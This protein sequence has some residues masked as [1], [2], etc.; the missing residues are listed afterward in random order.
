MSSHKSR[1]AAEHTA[2]A[3][4]MLKSAGYSGPAK[5]AVTK[6][7]S[8]LH[9]GQPKTFPKLASGG[10]VKGPSTVNV[11]IKTGG[12]SDAE[13]QQAAQQGMKM[14]A[15]MASKPPMPPPGPMAPPPPGAGP[16]AGPP[17]GI[18]PP[19]MHPPGAGGLKKGGVV[20]IRAHVR[21]AK[22]GKCE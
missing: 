4:S 13:K 16:M 19:G 12:S 5:A 9:M 21:R 18:P 2:K 8:K 20:K 15:M 22:G 6:H 3:N 7:E 17:G 11:I 1:S 10:K 14:G